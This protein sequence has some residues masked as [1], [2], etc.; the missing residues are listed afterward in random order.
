MPTLVR[1]NQGTVT[2]HHAARALVQ[3]SAPHTPCPIRVVTLPGAGVARLGVPER[4]AEAQP[5]PVDGVDWWVFG[6]C[7]W[8]HDNFL[9]IAFSGRHWVGVILFFFQGDA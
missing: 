1:L 2:P 6:G 4:A 3:Q 9:K 7:L 5:D 8:A